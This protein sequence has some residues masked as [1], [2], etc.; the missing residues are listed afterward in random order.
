MRQDVA[1]L[2]VYLAGGSLDDPWADLGGDPDLQQIP[3]TWGICRTNVRGWTRPGD[4]LFF[5]AKRATPA[6]SEQYF[7][8]AQ[9]RVA[10]KISHGAARRRFGVRWNVILDE[11]PDGDDLR[12][13]V[14]SYINCW[15]DELQ[16]DDGNPDVH[17]L[18][19]GAWAPDEFAVKCC[20]QWFVH[21]RWDPHPDWLQRLHAPFIVGD[22]QL[23]KTVREPIP[24][25]EVVARSDSEQLPGP[26]ELANNSRRHAARRVWE[27]ADI[28]LLRQLVATR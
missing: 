12:S 6:S 21:S 8:T 19:S 1:Y 18:R 27:P 20:A 22:E 24:W 17:R 7:L 16:W 15:L 26:H 2:L 23:S 14:A 11:L 3:M 4:D 13:Q 9:L 10:Q 25:A 28:E 5:I